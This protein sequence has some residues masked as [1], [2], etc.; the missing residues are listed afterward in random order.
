MKPSEISSAVPVNSRGYRE[1]ADIQNSVYDNPD[2]PGLASGF[3]RDIHYEIA[4]FLKHHPEG[5]NKIALCRELN[6]LRAMRGEAKKLTTA[7]VDLV[8]E[9]C[10]RH[11]PFI[12]EDGF[13]K[14]ICI[15][16]V[17]PSWVPPGYCAG[18]VVDILV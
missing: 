18:D 8:L 11:R 1:N 12:W 17:D 14:K 15:G 16:L 3:I 9:S 6:K 2:N 13:W 4:L 10:A 7:H 5:Y